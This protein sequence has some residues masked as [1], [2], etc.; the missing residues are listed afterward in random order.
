[1]AR[2]TYTKAIGWRVSKTKWGKILEKNYDQWKA[3]IEALGVKRD[4]DLYSSEEYYKKSATAL[5]HDWRATLR[6]HLLD[7]MT[8]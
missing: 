4:P 5:W 1:M 7:F 6:K 2:Y 3:T 8:G